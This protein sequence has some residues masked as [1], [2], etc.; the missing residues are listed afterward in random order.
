MP[1][2]QERRKAERVAA[3]RAP[4]QGAAAAVAAVNL[5][6]NPV[7]DWSTQAADP[8]VLFRAL[9]HTILKQRAGAGDREAQWS[10]GY[11]LMSQAGVKG[12]PLGE[13]GRSPKVDV[14][15]ALRTA[16][17]SALSRLRR[18]DVYTKMFTC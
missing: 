17:F 12:T 18:V 3:K 8:D 2:R 6:V 5:N 11:V 9:G 15:S 14:G 10:R 4:G 7:G 1:S 16:R 13:S